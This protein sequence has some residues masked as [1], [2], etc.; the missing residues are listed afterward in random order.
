VI[1]KKRCVA[2]IFYFQ[3]N[4][5]N[6]F[7]GQGETKYL[8]AFLSAWNGHGYPH[9]AV[10]FGLGPIHEWEFFRYLVL[11]LRTPNKG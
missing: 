10:G 4:R 8:L 9:V 1:E 5:L 3:P 7:A 11:K 2:V 6:I